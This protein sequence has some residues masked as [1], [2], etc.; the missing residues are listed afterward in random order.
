M[1]SLFKRKYKARTKEIK[2]KKLYNN[3]FYQIEIYE[4]E[5]SIIYMLIR[6]CACYLLCTL[7]YYKVSMSKDLHRSRDLK[8][9]Y[10]LMQ[11][12]LTFPLYALTISK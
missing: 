1:I 5:M 3:L 2:I 8:I 9:E 6:M 11:S 10:A 4:I 12:R 7:F